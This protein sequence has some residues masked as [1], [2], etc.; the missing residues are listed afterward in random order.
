VRC[1]SQLEGEAGGKTLNSDF[2]GVVES[3]VDALL[4]FGGG[5]DL[6]GNQEIVCLKVVVFGGKLFAMFAKRCSVLIL[7]KIAS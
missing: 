2:E 5:R 6:M 3:L 4:E 7:E 1:A